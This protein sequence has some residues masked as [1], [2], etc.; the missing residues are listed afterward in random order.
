MQAAHMLCKTSMLQSCAWQ[1]ISPQTC[2]L[3]PSL[4]HTYWLVNKVGL[5]I[6]AATSM[7]RWAFS[8]YIH[9]VASQR[10]S[11]T[12]H[13]CPTFGA[14]ATSSWKT[15]SSGSGGRHASAVLSLGMLR[16]SSLQTIICS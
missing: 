2:F 5:P 12:E 1:S 15:A 3:Q 14:P 8:R 9:R 10:I 13:R 16:A 4:P 6:E 11:D 7:M